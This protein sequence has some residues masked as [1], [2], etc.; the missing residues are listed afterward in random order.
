MISFSWIH[1]LKQNVFSSY[2]YFTYVIIQEELIQ[3]F[4]FQR[5]LIKFLEDLPAEE[6][7]SKHCMQL[8]IL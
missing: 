2:L 4:F 7:Q 3:L 8:L 6:K 5:F 1:V